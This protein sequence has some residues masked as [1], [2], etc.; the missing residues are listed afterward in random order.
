MQVLKRLPCYPVL[1]YALHG[2]LQIREDAT[3]RWSK[4]GL[5]IPARI[6]ASLAM[7]IMRPAGLR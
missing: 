6:A 5:L 1:T 4:A 2:P 3:N 7:S